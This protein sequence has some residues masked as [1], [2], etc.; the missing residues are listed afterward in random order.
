MKIF[1]SP[2][3]LFSWEIL[4]M[5]II[6]LAIV[7]PIRYFVFQ[8]FLVKGASM[9]PNFNNGDYLIVN[10]ISYKFEN[11]KRGEVIVFKYP[12]DPSQ[13]YIKRIIGLPG[14]TVEVAAGKIIIYKDS[15]EQV[16]N[17]SYLPN[18]I[19]TLGDL[20][21][22]LKTNEYFVLGDN[23][24]ASFDSRR[25]GALPKGNIIGKVELRAWPF[26]ALSKFEA[27]DYGY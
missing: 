2:L 19:R 4:K 23:R 9:Q 22:T 6:S 10:E 27:P 24:I 5:M 25:W 15:Q 11:P 18:Y 14:E 20:K 26:A 17:E 8:P 3:F 12:N 13:R 16:L 7:L 21:T 1:K